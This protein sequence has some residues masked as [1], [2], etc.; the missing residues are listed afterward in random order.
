MGVVIAGLLLSLY[1]PLF[2]LACA[3]SCMT[4]GNELSR[5]CTHGTALDATAAEASCTSAFRK[6]APPSGRPRPR[7]RAGWP[8]AIGCEFVDLSQFSID[9]ALFRASRPT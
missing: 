3:L 7:R 5:A 2:N 4:T 8:S 1:M 9:H 6:P